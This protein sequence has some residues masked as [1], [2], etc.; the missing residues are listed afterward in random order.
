M[1]NRSKAIV[2]FIVLVGLVVALY[3]F[4]DWFSK[5]TGLAVGEDPDNALAKCMT[6][7]GVKF[8]GAKSCPNCEKQK[9]L[10]GTSAFQFLNYIECLNSPSACANLKG[11]PAW[12]ING[13]IY[14]GI[15]T[16]DELRKL[17]RCQGA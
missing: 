3:L 2:T 6:E 4:T 15:K 1:E 8:Y 16:P 13:S 5:T 11:V 7:K 10:F 14:Y 12:Y 17:S 9:V